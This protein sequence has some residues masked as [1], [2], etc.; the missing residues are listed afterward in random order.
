MARKPS[1]NISP[2][3]NAQLKILSGITQSSE[4][5]VIEKAINVLYALAPKNIDARVSLSSLSSR[6]LASKD[7]DAE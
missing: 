2:E 1:L 5:E 4:S 3:C 7:E 6:A